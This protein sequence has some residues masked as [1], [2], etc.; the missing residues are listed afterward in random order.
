MAN[1]FIS[2]REIPEFENIGERDEYF[3]PHNNYNKVFN[4]ERI[5][6]CSEVVNFECIETECMMVRLWDEEKGISSCSV[7]LNFSAVKELLKMECEINRY[8]TRLINY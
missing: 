7:S 1:F 3:Q 8:M 5:F 4:F 2:L 6:E